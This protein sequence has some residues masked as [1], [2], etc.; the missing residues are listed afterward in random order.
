MPDSDSGTR[1]VT[2]PHTMAIAAHQRS[3]SNWSES[4]PQV[5][6]LGVSKQLE[7]VLKVD[8]DLDHLQARLKE[9]ITATKDFANFLKK[10]AFLEEEHA[11]GLRKI[12]RGIFDAA[13]R[14]DS[15]CAPY[16]T[17]Q[18]QTANNAHVQLAENGYQFSR[19]LLQVY[20]NLTDLA[21][22]IDKKRRD[23]KMVSLTNEK[24]LQ[25]SEAAVKSARARYGKLM[26]DKSKARSHA[27]KPSFSLRAPSL[28]ALTSSLGGG[29]TGEDIDRKLQ[30]ADSDYQRAITSAY[31]MEEIL[32]QIKRPE[33]I[34]ALKE[35]VFRI[36]SALVYHMHTFAELNEMFLAN[37]GYNISKIKVEQH[38][39]APRALDSKFADV[40]DGKTTLEAYQQSALEEVSVLWSLQAHQ[41]TPAPIQVDRIGA[42]SPLRQLNLAVKPDTGTSD[43][44][45]T[46][47][48]N[49]SGGP[50]VIQT[51]D[52]TP[53]RGPTFGVP[54]GDLCMRDRSV[55]PVLVLQCIQAVD[56]F[57]LDVEG[58]YRLSG[59]NTHVQN[60]KGLFNTDYDS[61][62][63][64]QQESFF[65]DI[66]SVASVLKQFF[67]ELPE[68]LLT[69]KLYPEF[70]AAARIDDYDD[71]IE[72]TQFIVNKLP[73]ANY[74]TLRGLMLHLNRVQENS[75][76]NK[77]TPTNLAIPFGPTLMD[78]RGTPRLADAAW[79]V[80]C[81]ETI[82]RGCFEIFDP[83]EA[84]FDK[85]EA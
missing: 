7:E 57:G 46:R 9:S 14:L 22:S 62:D 53:A 29:S 82:L 34:K 12:C 11:S 47:R 38:D 28:G 10:R 45:I 42:A 58:I 35:M 40:L 3:N 63:F 44:N 2:P 83:D 77:M 6:D 4:S 32:I 81:I 75:E 36:E 68:A 21:T 65:W 80:R 54:L 49:V 13:N 43:Q 59:T 73:D 48:E 72:A 15:T 67:R 84:G 31:E 18:M 23:L 64:R 60:I 70:I 41:S 24:K 1:S 66:N 17:Y 27:A 50:N 56:L 74:A 69:D 19:K 8:I 55:V 25:T 5:V 61:V 26:E 85:D 39:S 16:Y 79:Q 51:K 30:L 78:D 52:K 71:R 37:N 20:E 76:V 33:A